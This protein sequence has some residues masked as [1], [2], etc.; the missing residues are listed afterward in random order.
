M[1][2]EKL[3]MWAFEKLLAFLSFR[4]WDQ[5]V[6]VRK[7]LKPLR[8]FTVS[9]SLINLTTST[10]FIGF[11]HYFEFLLNIKVLTK[12]NKILVLFCYMCR[13]GM[14][15]WTLVSEFVLTIFFMDAKWKKSH[16]TKNWNFHIKT[17]NDREIY[18]DSLEVWNLIQLVWFF[19]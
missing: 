7:I 13:C 15:I 9:L 11:I 19:F 1:R 16:F 8:P 10:N 6:R 14:R 17:E 3:L 12:K 4:C 18:E 2:S 5:I